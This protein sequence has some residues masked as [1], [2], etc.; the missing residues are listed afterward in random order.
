MRKRIKIN[1]SKVILSSVIAFFAVI[2]FLSLPVLFNFNSMQNLLEKKFYSEFNIKL[3][4]LDDISFK[5]FPRPHYLV[6]NANLDLNIEDDKSSIIESKNLKIFIPIKKI[7]SKKNIKINSIEIANTNIYFK[8]SDVLDFR[9]HIYYKINGPIKIKKS[10][11]FLLDNNN[12]TILISPIKKI[13]YLIN[14]KNNSKEF[15][16][17]GNI[18]DV[19]YNSSWKRYYNKPKETLNEINLKN[20]NL[21]IKNVFSFTSNSNFNGKSSINFLNENF[22]INYL[23]KDKKIIINSPQNYNQKI[24]LTSNIELDPFYFDATITTDQKDINFLIDKFVNIILNSKAEYLGNINGNLTFNINNLKNSIIN[25]GKIKLSIREKKVKLEKS[26]F[27]ISG[28]GKISS[29]FRYYENK[30]DLIFASENIFE[31]LDKK[32]FAR[33]FQL[34][35]NKIKN[36]NKIYFDLEKNVDNGEIYISNI[37]INNVD[38]KNVSDE[39]YLIKNMLVFKNLIRNILS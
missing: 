7:Y 33:K 11:F 35:L 2:L 15:K 34:N 39:Y 23:V 20:P 22:I 30:G 31:I 17:N 37:H 28:I 25:S 21:L 14:K 9:N 6:K 32:E 16:I 8:L 5:I 19:N 24:K 18:F 10:K 13:N 38:L 1:S 4:I 36:I 27:E 12:K 26:L 3:K 29:D